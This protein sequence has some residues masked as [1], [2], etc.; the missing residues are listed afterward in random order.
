MKSKTDQ[1]NLLTKKSRGHLLLLLPEKLEAERSEPDGAPR[2]E[3]EVQ[4]PVAPRHLVD[5]KYPCSHEVLVNRSGHRDEDPGLDVVHGLQVVGVL[6]DPLKSR[7]D[8]K[9]TCTIRRISQKSWEQVQRSVQ[10]KFVEVASAGDVHHP[11]GQDKRSV[12]AFEESFQEVRQ[13]VVV[14]IGSGVALHEVHQPLIIS[15]LKSVHIEACC[16]KFLP[17]LVRAEVVLL[18]SFQHPCQCWVRIQ[19]ARFLAS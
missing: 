10:A 7:V 1:E 13:V 4:L 19:I 8:G 5:V 3:A 9:F 11:I 2:A 16:T 12:L 6:V 14:G 15:N 17:I 18:H